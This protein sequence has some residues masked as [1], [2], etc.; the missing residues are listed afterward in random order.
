MPDLRS[1][2][3]SSTMQISLVE[4]HPDLL[5]NLMIIYTSSTDTCSY[6]GLKYHEE[7]IRGKPHLFIFCC[8]Q[9]SVQHLLS[10]SAKCF[11]A[12]YPP[13][14]QPHEER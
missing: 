12:F 1:V 3:D 7:R 10:T 11:P 2:L 8:S 4:L 13:P 5:L 14:T 6:T 9:K